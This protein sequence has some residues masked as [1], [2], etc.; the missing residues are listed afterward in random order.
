MTKSCAE[1]LAVLA[2]QPHVRLEI[3]EAMRGS[4]ERQA[5]DLIELASGLLLAGVEDPKVRAVI[6]QAYSSYCD[7][8]I[9][10][11]LSLRKSP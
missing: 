6:T 1:N 10:A 11:F 2:V 9:S 3:P 8:L 4:I 5:R 7:E